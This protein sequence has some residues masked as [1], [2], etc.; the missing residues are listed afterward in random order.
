MPYSQ[1]SCP[2]GD[3]SALAMAG[4]KDDLFERYSV[5]FGKKYGE[6]GYGA[7]FAAKDNR[8]AEAL[9]CKIIDVLLLRMCSP[10]WLGRRYRAPCALDEG[11]GRR[12]S[13]CPRLL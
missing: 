10:K 7:T 3:H 8:T 11:S 12:S 13:I 4:G 2:A 1:P 9:A 5:D 6:G